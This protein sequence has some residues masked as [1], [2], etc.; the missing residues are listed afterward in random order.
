MITNAIEDR[1]PDHGAASALVTRA[2]FLAGL[3]K[4]E[5]QD[6]GVAQSAHR[7][8]A[9]YYC[10]Q[11]NYQK[12]HFIVDITSVWTQK[13]RALASYG[14]QFYDPNQIEPQTRISTQSFQKFLE[15]RAR[16][17]GFKIGVEY[18]EGF[19]SSQS[20]GIRSMNDIF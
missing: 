3:P 8:Q 18:G 1:H 12:P 9:L 4:I 20:I 15:A 7:P 11:G 14:S 19:L 17:L 6:E 2:A 16:T 10:I 5:T 13:M